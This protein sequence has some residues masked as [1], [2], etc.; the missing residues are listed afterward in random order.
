MMTCM[1]CI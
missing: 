1:D